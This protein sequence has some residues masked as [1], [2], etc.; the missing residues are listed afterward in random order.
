VAGSFNRVT[1]V[2][3]LGRDPE[4]RT[5]PSG[6]GVAD[7]SVATT[8]RRRSAGAGLGE[9]ASGQGQPQEITTWFRVSTFGKLAEIAHQYLHRGSYVYIEGTLTQRDY[10]DRDGQLRQSL[11][12]RARELRMLDRKEENSAVLAGAGA[13]GSGASEPGDLPF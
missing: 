5:L 11:E 10:T 13:A 7:F 2:G 4:W 12:V 3:N 9:S 8:E 1:I 6:D